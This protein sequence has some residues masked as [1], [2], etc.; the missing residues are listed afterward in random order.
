MIQT[1]Q[2]ALY[3][4]NQGNLQRRSDAADK[5][6]ELGI[7]VVDSNGPFGSVL[8]L[9]EKTEDHPR[10]FEIPEVLSYRSVPTQE[11]SDQARE[12]GVDFDIIE[13]GPRR[14]S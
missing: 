1:R 13:A 7:E 5:A 8:V 11:E 9:L 3:V 14:A 4:G 6:R 10:L 2:F 12:T